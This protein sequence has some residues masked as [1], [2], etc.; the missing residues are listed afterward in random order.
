VGGRSIPGLPGRPVSLWLDGAPLRERPALDGDLEVDIAVLGGGIVGVTAA[1]MVAREGATVALLEAR[2]I[3]FGVTGNTTAKLTSLHGLTYARLRGRIGD[4][5]ARSYGEANEAGIARIATL[6]DELGVDCDLRRKPNY[7]YSE[8]DDDRGEIE[9]EV[10]VATS[11]GLPAAYTEETDLPYRVAA[12]VRFDDQAEFHPYRYLTALAEAAEG[13]GCRIYEQ[14]T[15]V[16][17]ADREVR[18]AGGATVRAERVIVAT[19]IPFVDRGLYFARTHPERSYALAVRVACEPLA[20]MY[21]SAGRPVRSLR[22]QPARGGELLIVAGE[23]HRVGA[24]DE[25]ERYRRLEE[26]ARE[27]FPVES[28]EHRWSAQD[29]MP[30]DGLPYVGRLLP[31]T[32]RVLVATG[33]RKWGLAM[34]AASGSILADMAVGRKP[35]RWTKAFD[36]ARVHPVA[37]ARGLLSHNAHAAL[38]FFG[39][40]VTMRGRAGGIERGEGRVVA[41]GLR[42]AAVYR[43][44]EGA[45]HE[46][47]ARCTH[48]GCLVRWNGAEGT[49]DCP[50]HGSRFGP[51]GDVVQ[52]P[53]TAPL[54]RRGSFE[55]D[56]PG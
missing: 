38:A 47:S 18:T 9:R 53:A 24:G 49:W 25:P 19:H 48:L 7:T 14:T 21:L 42:Q 12:A 30:V 8:S 5:A 50:C 45:V 1:L 52:G 56:E 10:E 31:F 27:R 20:G 32:D 22:S 43:D 44:P 34:G 55:S 3:G 13:E 4:D 33:F 51:L 37:S 46:L 54:A 11:L 28:I 16:G 2:R 40:R 29:N 23:S 15:A 35:A 41:S 36:P 6:T 17:I 39:D 26:F